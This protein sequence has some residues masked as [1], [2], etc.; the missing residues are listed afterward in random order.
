MIKSIY[1]WGPAVAWAAIIF[2]FSQQSDP[3]GGE[4]PAAYDY[5]VHFLE[6]GVFA[7]TLVWGATSGWHRSFTLKS[8]VGAGVVAVL[9][10]LSDEWHQSLVPDRDASLLDVAADALGST[11]G[12]VMAYWLGKGK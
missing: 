4:W 8:A 10:A 7:L 3:P 5:V 2:S 11:T 6:Y 1:H 9:Y 12:V